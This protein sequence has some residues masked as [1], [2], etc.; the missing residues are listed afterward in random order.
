M[1]YWAR[2]MQSQLEAWLNIADRYLAWIE[3]LG[4][5]TAE[6]IA[7]LDPNALPAFRQ[8]LHHAPSL[9]DLANG[10]LAWIQFLQE[11]RKQAPSNESAV[12]SWIDR[13]FKALDQSKWLAGEMLASCERLA[14]AG[15]ELSESMNM[16]FLYN[17]DRRLFS[18][19]YN[20]T[21]GRLDHAY[22]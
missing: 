17:A 7:V 9:Q 6:E 15:R 14:Q 4:E 3:I 10:N 18:I 8:A 16:R 21:E 5:K 19:G 2:Q 12:A 13:V 11:I 1:A 20:V 22:L